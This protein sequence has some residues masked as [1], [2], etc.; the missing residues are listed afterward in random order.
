LVWPRG[1]QLSPI[2]EVFR[3]HV[4]TQAQSWVR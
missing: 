2:A 3:T 1:K 4:L